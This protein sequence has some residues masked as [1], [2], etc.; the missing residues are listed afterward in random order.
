[1][2]QTLPFL[3]PPAQPKQRRCGN[4]T[5]GIIELPELGGLTVGESDTI[6]KLSHT[7]ESAFVVGARISE[8]ISK[9]EGISISEAFTI[10]E[11]AISGMALEGDAI[12]LRIKYAE[13]IERLSATFRAE[14]QLL[15]RAKVTAVLRHRLMPEWTLADTD[16]LPRALFADILQLVEDEIS[17]ENNELAEPPDDE[18]LG[19]P[20]EANGNNRKRI[21]RRSAGKS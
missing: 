21:G 13:D 2:T 11:K 4:S 10:A 8:A 20:P 9:A 6:Q 15:M 14:N 5:S 3:T 1:M 18:T 7:D 17:A 19:K 12:P 16:T